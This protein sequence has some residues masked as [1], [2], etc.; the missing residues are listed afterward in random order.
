MSKK[1]IIFGILFLMMISACKKENQQTPVVYVAGHQLNGAD[2]WIAKYWKNGKLINLSDGTKSELT[3]TIVV[4]NGNVYVSGTAYYDGFSVAKYWKNGTGINLTD[5]TANAFTTDMKV[6]NNDIY[7]SGSVIEDGIYKA[8][9]WKN[10]IINYLTNGPNYA[11]ASSI[12]ILNNNVFVGGYKRAAN[13][14]LVAMYWKNSAPFVISTSANYSRVDDIAA[15]G[16]SVISF[17]SIDDKP[18]FWLANTAFEI[19]TDLLTPKKVV[20]NGDDMYILFSGFDTE[21]DNRANAYLKNGVINII[22]EPSR[23]G[24]TLNDI[25]ISG[26]DVYLAGN[27]TNNDGASPMIAHYWKNGKSY[28]LTSENTAE[29]RAEATSVFVVE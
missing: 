18:T 11:G 29:R 4:Q 8:V 15:K 2:N 20:F 25:F 12:F 22:D 5:G 7:I 26:S 14:N 1:S 3:N 10:G 13:G 9:Y 28:N 24:I 27:D 21:I 19:V 23:Q 17:G 16:D 6:V